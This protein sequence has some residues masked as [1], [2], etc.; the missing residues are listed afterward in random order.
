MP[1]TPCDFI[2]DAGWMLP[3]APSN[4][5]LRSASIAVHAGRICK[6]G[7]SEH[8]HA[9]FQAGEVVSLPHHALMPGLINA[10]GHA[11]MSL[12]RGFAEDTELSTWLSEQIWPTEARWVDEHF[13]RTGVRLA[14]IE[15]LRS[16]TTCFSD[17][18]FFPEVT[19]AVAAEVGMRA[20]IAF[21]I[22]EFPN[23]WSANSDEGF[24]K[25]LALHDA[26]RA[27][28]T[29]GIAFGP[30][31]AYTVSAADLDRIL[32]YSEELGANVQI[33]LHETAEEVADAKSRVGTSWV[34]YL[35]EHGLLGPRL[36]AVHATQLTGEEIELMAENGVKV[37]HCPYSNLK[38]ASGMCPTPQLMRAGVQVGLGTDS[39]ASNNGLDLLAEAR[40]AVLLG[41]HQ[42]GDA[43]AF[44]APLAVELATLGGARAL[45][46]E[47][48][49]GTLE[50]GKAADMVAVDLSAPRF[51]P[52]YDPIA[53]LVHTHA[54]GAV[55]DVWI[56]GRRL[57][58]E[59]QL[60]TLEEPAVLA[61]VA[62]WQGRIAS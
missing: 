24:H 49:T 56:G 41:K 19:A 5:V 55:S 7:D 9:E 2:I 30:H 28:P 23:A 16:G 53:Q 27:D 59:G 8:I 51:Q 29:I 20:Q 34:R 14:M 21:P 62:S 37:V 35:S 43:S 40:L 60:T 57:L 31:A 32:M 11:A 45:G 54:G 42:S 58:Q 46:I 13:V 33:H 50:A 17:M 39:A 22:I 4:A 1:T 44:P 15:M 3:V 12:L 36:Q 10:H 25:G 26:Y 52:L 48:D 38:L 18:Y 47:D 6:L 61:D